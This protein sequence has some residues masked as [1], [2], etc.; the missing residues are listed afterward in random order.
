MLLG[1]SRLQ[2]HRPT[3]L[4]GLSAVAPAGSGLLALARILLLK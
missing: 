3:G 4:A 2:P 1:V